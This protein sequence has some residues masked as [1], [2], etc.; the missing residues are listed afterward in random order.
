[1]RV[2]TVWSFILIVGLTLTACAKKE[3]EVTPPQPEVTGIKGKVIPVDLAGRA[4]ADASGVKVEVEGIGISVITKA[5]GSF[6]L[7]D[8]PEGVYN[9][10]LSKEGY[11]PTRVK[12]VT[13]EPNKT[14]NLGEVRLEKGV[15]VTG[16]VEIEEGGPSAS[17]I[18]ISVEDTPLSSAI[19]PDGTYRLE[20]VA[21][22]TR[23][24][25]ISA[26]DKFEPATLEI[27]VLPDPAGT[28]RDIYIGVEKQILHKDDFSK[29]YD[30]S[31]GA[32]GPYTIYNFS[33]G[34]EKWE[35][36][37]GEA[38]GWI[39]AGSGTTLLGFGNESWSDYTVEFR[40]KFESAVGS[41][42]RFGLILGKL[43][44]GT[45][46]I[47]AIDHE[48]GAGVIRVRVGGGD[49]EQKATTPI[50]YTPDKWYKFKVTAS[51]GHYEFFIDGNKIGTYDGSPV[52]GIMYLI[53]TQCSAR[54]D[55]LLVTGPPAGKPKLIAK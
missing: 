38:V 22:G 34:A 11:C 16:K 9:V 52:G 2:G 10:L 53:C 13:V 19:R 37:K 8:V 14:T 28:S 21:P 48:A 43:D 1:V 18:T 30:F 49:V 31:K 55:D 29:A 40:A 23:K 50:K 35:I 15:P 51:G 36:D 32:D 41:P 12:N 17:D 45:Y 3:E 20:P 4:E 42:T 27:E 44:T 26:G 39:S 6:V 25:V 7:T 33:A 54:F 24:L 46:N 47:F 5:D